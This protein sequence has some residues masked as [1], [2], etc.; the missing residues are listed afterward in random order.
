MGRASSLPLARRAKSITRGFG[1]RPNG[2]LE[3]CPTERRASLTGKGASP[4][5]EGA[6]STAKHPGRR[7]VSS[8]PMLTTLAAGPLSYQQVTVFLLAFGVL[9]GTA[10]L[11]GEI[12]RKFGQPTVLG[13]ILAGV[14]LGATV[15]GN[16]GIAGEDG[17][18]VRFYE[19][20]FPTYVLNEQ[21]EPVQMVRVKADPEGKAQ[22]IMEE[23][24]ERATES[25]GDFG[26]PAPG[27]SGN[28]AGADAPRD[29]DGDAAQRRVEGEPPGG[30]GGGG[31]KLAVVEEEAAKPGDSVP[32]PAD[33]EKAYDGGFLAMTMFLNLSAVF[34]L[35][36]AGL[37][38][39]LS[40]V[41]K[42][43]KAAL[44]VSLMGMLVPGAFGFALAYALPG[45]LG[46]DFEA[47]QKLPFALFVAIAMSITALPVIAKILLDL[48]MFRSDM[49]MLIM[50]SAMVNDLI[51]WIGF[52]V[53]LALVATGMEGEAAGA[54]GDAS[55]GLMKTIGL[56]FLF[57]G[58]ML[59][60]GRFLA[61]KALPFVQANTSWP[62]GVLA[63]VLTISLLCAAAT[64][65]IGIHSIFGAFIAGVAIGD[66][67]HLREQ[68]RTVIEQFITNIF[69]PLFFAGIGLRVNFIEGFDIA[70]VS[71]V[72]GVAIAG[73]VFGCY[74][75][76]LW[77]GLSRRE[78]WAV[79]FGM[80]AR[81]AMEII[82][83]QL[84]LQHNLITEKL[85]VAIVVMAIATSLIAGPSMQ[86]ALGRKQKRKLTDFL[87]EKMFVGQLR[88]A[89]RRDAIRELA[90]A[91]S[92]N[93]EV[94]QA[95][96]DAA[97]WR[98]EQMMSTGLPGGIAV[99]HGRIKGLEK[100]LVVVGRSNAGI[101]FDAADGRLAEIVCLLLTP[102]SDGEAQLELLAAV[103]EAFS[104][105]TTRRRALDAETF[106]EFKAALMTTPAATHG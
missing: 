38:V 79:G 55:S 59:T 13:E 69:A 5:G 65:A 51:G 18:N 71:I 105:P 100:P 40:I 85:F 8:R 67:R 30:G 41:W 19:Y 2:R 98:R 96:C 90:A 91:A 3:A 56:T 42:Q 49:G 87:S 1:L 92:A 62:G 23:P 77:A 102:A 57:V 26:A 37:E 50:S 61:N 20:L 76:A 63:F 36:V 10:R 25:A 104:D 14:V 97:V 95:V 84:A 28:P 4:T 45:T 86:A 35:L 70:A 52:A 9:L 80:S 15:L 47:G 27:S 31:E 101:D 46:Y 11:F 53:V 78:S 12:A 103:A 60:V 75:G 93:A 82:L 73:K 32:L 39:D 44:F 29:A 54:A 106:I 66:S 74:F 6:C 83:G 7:R 94:D 89:T 99:P 58:G 34:L 68:T 81:G 48:N 43:G 88:S 21:N 24:A 16:P 33:H 17:W 72:L 22:E 64:E